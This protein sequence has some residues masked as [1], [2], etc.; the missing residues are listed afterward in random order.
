MIAPG[1]AD[2]GAE[3]KPAIAMRPFFGLE[4]ILMDEKG[5]P[6]KDARDAHGAL[7]LA[8]PWPG[9]ARTIHGDHQ[10]FI[11]T[12]FKQYP[13]YYFT[14]DGAHIFSDGYFGITGRMDDVIN[15][16]GHRLGT[17]EIEDVLV[18]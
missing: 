7:C 4:P 5:Q 3:V 16:S 8:R 17:A 14:G 1:P 11:D 18:G 12:Y 10:R 2:P 6:M 13:G 15:V 9:I